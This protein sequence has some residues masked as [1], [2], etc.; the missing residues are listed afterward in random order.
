MRLKAQS[1]PMLTI[2]AAVMV[3]TMKT[4]LYTEMLR[5]FIHRLKAMRMRT[6]SFVR[7]QDIRPL[8]GQP[9]NLDR[10]NRAAMLAR[11]AVAPMFIR[12]ALGEEVF[13]RDVPPGLWREPDLPAKDATK[14]GNPV[15]RDFRH[16][17]MQIA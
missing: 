6:R 3:M 11:Q 5:Q 1:R 13:G 8:H 7:D 9:G 16:A 4:A 10:K 17:A 12:P 2:I 15:A 14:T